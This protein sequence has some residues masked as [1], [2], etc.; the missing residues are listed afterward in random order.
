MTNPILSYQAAGVDIDAG[1][2]LIERIKP[3]VKATQR[4]EVLSSLGGFSGLFQLN[5]QHYQQ[6]VL[7][8]CT[9]GVGTKLKLAN[10]PEDYHHL[11]ID[12]VAMSVN[13]LLVIGAEPLFF[14]DYYATGKLELDQAEQVIAGIAAGCQQAGCAL[15]GGETAEMPG[16][17]QAGDFDLAGFCVGI[18]DKA[19]LIDGSRITAGD[20]LIGL[21]SSGI[22]ANGYS[23]VRRILEQQGPISAE[24]HQRL[25]ASTCIYHEA[26]KS[27][28]AAV[29]VKGMAHI[30][31]GGLLDNI[32]RM[33]P[34]HC[35]ANIDTNS[36][37]KP[38]IYDW[39]AQAAPLEPQEQWR[40]FNNGIGYVACVAEASVA[41]AMHALQSAGQKAWLIG[42]IASQSEVAPSVQ[43]QS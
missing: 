2:E 24:L 13:D 38:A 7:V 31:G 34:N 18:A 43:L 32:P 4:P 35:C 9:D 25:L 21:A 12:L 17:Y 22:H 39:L 37:E 15:L 8:S 23:L 19:K 40:T 30:T 14:L 33:L 1:N 29:T 42:E 16:V 36:W 28:C 27:L 5:T 6:P 3:H 20:K 41:A 26:V 11:G 10:S